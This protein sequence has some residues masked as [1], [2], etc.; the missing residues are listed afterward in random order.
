MRMRRWSGRGSEEAVARRV[1]VAVSEVANVV[2]VR[3][4][5]DRDGQYE[6]E[7][8]DVGRQKA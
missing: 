1:G 7:R 8:D 4:L 2:V 3:L 6:G 5:A